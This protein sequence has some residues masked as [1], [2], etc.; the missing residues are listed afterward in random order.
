[1]KAT[2]IALA[3]LALLLL[4]GLALAQDRKPLPADQEDMYT[5]S[6]KVGV[7]NIVEGDVS[8]K[9][10][11]A[12][13]VRLMAGDELREGDAVK[14]GASGRAEI[15]L[16]PGC[17][18]RLAENSA[19]VLTNPHVYQFR[20]DLTGGTAIVEA[21]AID[22][23]MT[24]A[25]PKNEFSIIKEGLYRFN[26]T[27]DG[28]AEAIVRKGRLAVSNTVVKGD[29][30]AIV[31]GG[32]PQ[33]ASFNKKQVDGFDTWSEDRARDLIA[34]NKRLAQRG[35]INPTT[36]AFVSN[37]WIYSR[38]CGCYTFL[39]FGSGFSSPY[40]WDYSVCN[41]Y[42]GS[43]SFFPSYYWGTG[44]YTGSRSGNSGSGGYSGGSGGT[45]GGNG[46]GHH[47]AGRGDNPGMGLPRPPGRSD[48]NAGSHT[49]WKGDDGPRYNPPS[50]GDGG[51]SNRSY[52][53]GGGSS[54]HYSAPS[55]APSMPSQSMPSAPVSSPSV[56]GG[57]GGGHHKNN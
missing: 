27:A 47:K 57:G 19:F 28:R 45:G 8:Y 9:R 30:K 3:A 12:D 25:T 21:S 18:L 55:S 1:M 34:L 2:R 39:P 22:G 42:Y 40:G 23:P 38:Q 29:N 52:S 20:I 13:W 46:G 35:L 15:L 43:Y 31:E 56:S 24:V 16:T 4:A 50:R 14:T 26:L 54:P 37:A 41:P 51:Q 36:L 5:V 10:D 33:V 49:S 48:S 44:Y 53:S 6:A 11:Q 17:Y 32:Q 7:L